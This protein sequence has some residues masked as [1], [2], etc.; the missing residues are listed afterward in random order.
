MLWILRAAPVVAPAMEIKAWVLTAVL[1]MTKD[2]VAP[3]A[4]LTLL[5]VT[6]NARALA[7]WGVAPDAV[8]TGTTTPFPAPTETRFPAEAVTLP[9][10]A[11]TPVA[12]VT[13]VPADTEPADA[14]MLPKV[15]TMLPAD[16]VTPPVVA[17]NPVPAVTV[18]PAAKLVVVVNDPGAVIAAGNEMVDTPATV[19]TVT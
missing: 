15:A 11:T 9:V 18:V 13:V 2:W 12:P 5:N 8:D 14:V 17:I 6:A 7:V 19:L 10:V 1:L 3:A 16:A 4:M